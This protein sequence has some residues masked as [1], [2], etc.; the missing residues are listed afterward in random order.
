MKLHQLRDPA[1]ILAVRQANFVF[2]STSDQKLMM[3]EIQAQGQT[4]G[5]VCT[6]DLGKVAGVHIFIKEGYRNKAWLGY[7]LWLHKNV[8]CPLMK[9]LGF[10][11]LMAAC[12]DTNEGVQK[13]M[14]LAGFEV[15]TQVIGQLKL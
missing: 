2:P 12:E 6:E 5:Y 15:T 1:E 3:H 11:Y 9:E 10:E 8:Y 14:K 4:F 7:F 13:L